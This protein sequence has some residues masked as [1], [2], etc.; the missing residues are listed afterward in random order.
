MIKSYAICTPTNRKVLSNREDNDFNTIYMHV[1]TYFQGS[2][3]YNIKQYN[4]T[5]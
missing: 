4:S 2:I 1:E 5:L 3:F